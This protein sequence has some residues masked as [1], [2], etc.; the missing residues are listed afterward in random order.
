MH[1]PRPS[2]KTHGGRRGIEDSLRPRLPQPVNTAAQLPMAAVGVIMLTAAVVMHALKGSPSLNTGPMA[3]ALGIVTVRVTPLPPRNDGAVRVTAPKTSLKDAVKRATTPAPVAEAKAAAAVIRARIFENNR[4]TGVRV[5]VMD[6][7]P[8]GKN[9]AIVSRLSVK[10]TTEVRAADSGV[11]GAL[12]SGDSAGA[13]ALM[14]AANW[15]PEARAPMNAVL[16]AGVKSRGNTGVITKGPARAQDGMEDGTA[17]V[18][19]ALMAMNAAVVLTPRNFVAAI[20]APEAGS[21]GSSALIVPDPMVADR[22]PKAALMAVTR[23]GHALSTVNGAGMR[24]A[25]WDSMKAAVLTDE[26]AIDLQR[27]M[28]VVLAAD[29]MASNEARATACAPKAGLRTPIAVRAAMVIA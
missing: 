4:R 7:V 26:I 20:G 28:A 17:D 8:G 18:A 14:E 27:V 24:A 11:R 3:G 12:A 13:S 10:V 6:A 25:A 29:P 23:R 5:M 16:R 19:T 2:R 9:P 21:V 1:R 22:A 15:E